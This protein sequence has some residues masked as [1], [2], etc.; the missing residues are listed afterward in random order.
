MRVVTTFVVTLFLFAAP[1]AKYASAAGTVALNVLW[2]VFG[3]VLRVRCADGGTP[4]EARRGCG[5]R[6]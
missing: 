3:G 4:A 6:A 2:V 1:G 5:A